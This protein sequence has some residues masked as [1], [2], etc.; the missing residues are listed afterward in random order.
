MNDTRIK[1]LDKWR[2]ATT[3]GG[4]TAW[5][6]VR[7]YS[8][9]SVEADLDAAWPTNVVLEL[10]VANDQRYPKLFSASFIGDTTKRFTAKG[11]IHKGLD[12]TDYEWLGVRINT[13]SSTS[14]DTVNIFFRATCPNGSGQFEDQTPKEGR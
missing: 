8:T 10:V 1:K 5:F 13:G 3:Q 4:D 6:N 11:T 2:V 9:A 14:T 12:V 7:G